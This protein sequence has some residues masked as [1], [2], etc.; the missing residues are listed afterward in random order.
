MLLLNTLSSFTFQAIVSVQSGKME[1]LKNSRPGPPFGRRP[2]HG[3]GPPPGRGR[4]AE[5]RALVEQLL[6]LVSSH[7]VTQVTCNFVTRFMRLA[8]C[9]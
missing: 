3:R 2:P 5:K 7:T 4:P 1:E 8:S 6:S 9:Q